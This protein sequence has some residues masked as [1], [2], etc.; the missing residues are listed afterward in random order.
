M[1][2]FFPILVKTFSGLEPVLAEE[3]E[4][5]GGKNLRIGR[6]AVRCEGDLSL[7]YSIN[8]QARTALRVLLPIHQFSA[9]HEQ[10]LYRG[11][12]QIDW[13]KFIGVNQTLA[14]DG[15]VR[16]SFF[17][18]SHYVALKTKDAIAD[19]FRKHMGRRPSVNTDNPHV[20][21]HVH[22]DRREVSVSLDSSGS[23]LH[24]R[25]YRKLQGQAP[26]NE[27]LAAGMVLLSG[28]DGKD[29]FIDPMCG[30]GSLLLEAAMLA[31]NRSP[32]MRR[33]FGFE[34]WKDF[35]PDLWKDIR[36][37]AK[38]SV[39][40]VEGLIIGRD[41]DRNVLRKTR[42]NLSWAGLLEEISVESG[43]FLEA[44]APETPGMLIMNPPYGERMGKEDIEGFYQQ[45]GDRLKQ[46][47]PGYQACILS[48][49]A[50]AMKRIGLRAEKKHIL[51]NGSLECRYH[52]YRLYQGRS[53]S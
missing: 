7:V 51:F 8:L 44:P 39:R 38:A 15:V 36:S 4:Q 37:A 19:Q 35:Q 48:S 13:R 53:N 47:Y 20:R 21:V 52:R 3:L 6:R 17:R 33:S 50:S 29:T 46:E 9:Q 32:G 10:Q 16:S 43:D 12:Q 49:N 14:V 40:P 23:S 30:S 31:G 25:G 5:L 2:D 18:H 22:I 1:A 28:W 11:I 34:R 24:L 42:E 27:V 45:M 26:L 41:H